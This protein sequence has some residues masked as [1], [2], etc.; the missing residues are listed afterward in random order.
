MKNLF[1]TTGFLAFFTSIAGSVSI[2]NLLVEY[3]KTPIGIDVKTPRFSWQMISPGTVRGYKQ[4]AYQIIVTDPAG[5]ICWN[6]KKISDEASLGIAYAGKA[7]R[8]ETRYNWKVSV[9]DQAGALSTASSWFETG[10]MNPD[11][12]LAAWNGAQW[13]GGGPADI[14]F[15]PHYLVIFNLKYNVAIKEGSN[16]ASFVYGANDSRLMDKNKNIFQVQ[17]GKNENYIR[18]ELDI[19]AVDGT[20]PGR[21]KLNIYRAGYKDTDNPSKPIKSWDIFTSIINKANKYGE[22]TIAFSSKFG[23]ISVSVDGNNKFTEIKAQE[24]GR[25]PG[26]GERGISFNLNPVGS[27]GNY[28]PYGMLCDIGFSM[29]PG[30]KATFSDL[31]VLNNRFPNAVLFNE[32]L[33]AAYRGIYSNYSAD[34]NSG[35]AVANGKYVLTGTGNGTFIVADPGRNSTPLLRTAFKAADKKIKSARLYTTARGIYEV[36]LN[37]KRVGNDYYNPG[38]T[39][40]N[41]THLYQTYDITD[42]IKPGE[43]AI[44]AMLGEGW[45]SGLL[46]FGDIWNHFGDRQSFLAKLVITYDDETSEVVTTDNRNWKYYNKSPVIYSSLD[47]G[48]IYDAT[49]ESSIEG[50]SDASFNDSSWSDAVE[51]PLQGTAF[52]GKVSEM[53]GGT[54][55]FNFDKLSLTGQIGNNAGIFRVLTAQN[56]KE[57]RKGVFVYDMGQNIVG[58]PRIALTNG[59]AGQRMTLRFAEMLYPDL[60]ESGNNVGMIMLE[61]YRA[62]LSQDIYIMKE[63]NQVYQPKFTSHGFKY[64]EITGIDT[65]LPLD[66]VQS[67]AISSITRLTSDYETSNNKVN[68]L[69]SNLVWSNIDNFLTIPT[70]CPQRNERMGWSGDISVFSRTATYVSNSDQFLRRHMI[71]MRDVQKPSGKF[72]DVSPVGGGFGGVLWGS[73]G[74]TVAW[75]A[76]QQYNDVELLKEH[77]EAMKA[78]ADYLQ[79]TIDPKTG[80]STDGQLGDWLGP[81]NNLLGTAFLVTAYH[82]YDLWMMKEIAGILGKSED[83]ARFLKMYEERKEFFNRKFVNSDHKTMGITGGGGGFGRPAAAPELKLAD[84]QTSY[85]VG[86]ALGAFSKENESYMAKN[87]KETVERENK[88]D[89]GITRP[90]NSLMTGFIGTAWISKALSDNGYSEQA[91]RLLQNNQYPSWLYS[92][93]QGATTIW[94]RLNGYTVENGFGGNNSM[95][96]FNHYSF[97]AV[98]QWMIAYSLGIQRGEPGFKKFIL[99]PEPDPTGQMTWAKGFYDSMYGRISSSWK[100]DGGIL[101]YEG[102]VP[103]NTTATL[104]LPAASLKNITESGKP[105]GKSKGVKFIKMENG[106][107]VYNLVSGNYVFVVGN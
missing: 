82:V 4:V 16:R 14:V 64:I 28:I 94:E 12:G 39:Q 70:D 37:G 65:P 6:S 9:W 80:L 2:D 104:Y 13:I 89:S 90:K 44:G 11:P 56:V 21:A 54:S 15:Y 23:E 26:S 30:Q 22:H 32:D 38:L 97:G 66:A 1:L 75:E 49:R 58:V 86:L 78:Y 46:S 3:T 93:D 73:A 103:A 84:N 55:D 33:S 76:F 8:A 5:G 27:G 25:F 92:I 62:A 59:H 17:T 83:G 20:E 60:K 7:L 107:A 91:Y 41:I 29:E 18:V 106:K 88:D 42:Y 63:G 81:Q 50:W 19:S 67:V 105:A 71:A 72:A 24:G 69:W 47:M 43:N 74:I 57:V 35:F 68:R 51:V 101:T 98:G 52:R 96:S 36:Y 95:N 34:P 48:E 87:L 45:W 53:G 102:S 77:F 61:N 40:Y 100:I 99:Q 10:L 85:A 79:T 31:T